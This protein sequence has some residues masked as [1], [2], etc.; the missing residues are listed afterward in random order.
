MAQRCAGGDLRVYLLSKLSA[1]TSRRIFWQG[2]YSSGGSE[3][4]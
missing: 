1:H 4:A 2:D 3:Q